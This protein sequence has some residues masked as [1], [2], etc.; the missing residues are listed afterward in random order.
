MKNLEIRKLFEEFNEKYKEYFL[1][2][3]TIWKDNLEKVSA[4]IDTNNKPP[5]DR[6]KDEEIKK[7]GQW[8][9]NKKINYNK[10]AYIMKEPEIRKLWEEFNEKYKEHFLDNVKK[11]KDNLEKVSAYI[12]TNNKPPSEKNKNGEIKKLGLWLRTQKENYNKNAYIMKEPEI[13]KLFKEFIEKYKE[14]F[15]DN[16]TICKESLQKV[17][18]YIDTNNKPPTPYDKDEEIK[19]LGK[20]LSHQKQNYNKKTKIMKEPEIRKLFEEFIE[21]YKEHFLDNETIWKENLQKVSA[22][23]DTNNKPPSESDKNGD[24]KKLG[25]WLS[26]QKTN[27]NK[28]AQIMKEPEI[29]KLFEEFIEKYKE[30]FLDNET[31]WKEILQKVSAYIDTNNKPP[32]EKNKNGEIKKLGAWLGTQKTN[33]KKETKIMKEP[34]IRKLF[35]EFIEKYKEHFKEFVSKN[36]IVKKSVNIKP[37]ITRESTGDKNKRINSEY[38]EI[39]RKMSSQNSTTTNDMFKEDKSLWH[40]YHDFRDL[41]FKGYDDQDEIPVNKIINYLK[42]KIKFKL[43]ILD[44]GCGRNLIQEHFKSSKKFTI[45]GYDHVSYNGSIEADISQLPEEDDTINVC[46]YS[47]SLMGSNWKKYLDEGKRVLNYHG[48]MIISESVERYD[49]IKEYLNKLKLHIKKDKYYEDK[50]WFYIHA[51]KD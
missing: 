7:L 42:T 6:D 12:D 35:E 26:H 8:L 25:K 43:K 5:S 36:K 18:Q 29:R 17:S 39:S 34:E 45:T 24:I 50:R 30:H 2:N 11:W 41:S 48:E 28:K 15:L 14:H 4:Y 49:M 32:S 1:D 21:K 19:K 9:S 33:Y 22:Y 27:Y 47:Q 44:L 46:V 10:N 20:W 23:I 51:I 31:I 40:K 37:K 3:E 16:E 13:R 38:Q